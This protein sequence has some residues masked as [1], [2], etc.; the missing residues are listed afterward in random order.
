VSRLVPQEIRELL[1]LCRFGDSDSADQKQTVRGVVHTFRLHHDRVGA[2]RRK[3]EELLG[4]LPTEFRRTGK[5][6]WSFLY[7]CM[8]RHGAQWT[9]FHRDI[10]I[11][12]VLGIAIGKVE[13]QFPR[14]DW[15]ALPGAM[16]YIVIDM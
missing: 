4:E 16:P 12:V 15:P 8:D 2:Q 11:L 14:E 13:F 7:A 5:G 9:G 6:G 1:E 3:I 10:E